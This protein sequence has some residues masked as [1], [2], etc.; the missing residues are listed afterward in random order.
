MTRGSGVAF[1]NKYKV[2]AKEIETESVPTIPTM[3]LPAF[4]PKKTLNKNPKKGA[5]SKT[6][7]KLVS[8]EDY[9][10]KFFKFPT[11]IVPKFLKTDTKMAK[12]TATSA[13]ATA[14]E[15]NTKTCPCAS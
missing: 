7:T 11:S 13:A 1:A 6:K 4:L 2:N 15:K 9:P 3:L 8:I 5:N 14:I 10:F 12:P